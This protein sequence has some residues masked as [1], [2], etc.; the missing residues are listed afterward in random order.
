MRVESKSTEKSNNSWSVLLSICALQKGRMILALG[1]IAIVSC[2]QLLPIYL[3]F[4]AIVELLDPVSTSANT[5]LWVAAGLI[6]VT[7]FKTV[8][9]VGAYYFSHQ[10]AYKA[11]TDVRMTLSTNLASAS[12]KWL[13]KQNTAVLK[14]QILHD[15][16]KLEHFIAHNSVELFN[17]C[18]SP[19]LIFCALYLIDWRLALSAIAVVPLAFLVSGFFMHKTAEHYVQFSD[20]EADLHTTLNDY[21]KYA[22][23]MK[24]NNLDSQRFVTLKRKL[25]TYQSTVNSVIH[26]TVPGWALYSA[27]LGS[28][29]LFLLPTAIWLHSLQLVSIEHL[30]LAMLLAIGMMG[31][32]LKVSRFF[33]EANELLSSISRIA[34]LYYTDPV[35]CDTTPVHANTKY[36]MLQ[37]Y[38]VDFCYE[39]TPVLRNVHFKLLPNA[40]NVIVGGTG[41]GKSTL[42]MLASG[43]LAPSAGRV[44]LHGKDVYALS[45]SVRAQA[46]SVVTQEN[47]LFEGTVRDNISFGRSGV[48]TETLEHAIVAAQLKPWLV[49]QPDGLDTRVEARGINL[50]GGEKIRI[51]IARAILNAPP[52]VILDEASAAMD[53]LTHAKF[54]QGLKGHYP[55][56]TFLVITHNYFGLENSDQIFTLIDGTIAAQGTHEAMLVRCEHY[57]KGWQ[58]QGCEHTQRAHVIPTPLPSCES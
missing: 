22:P 19:I 52:L 14:Q 26:Q 42:A 4:V 1:L 36:P 3:L 57:R 18:L 12:L 49:R 50:S 24:L 41:S 51:A 53:N 30:V 34:P 2:A 17:A 16:E 27:L 38:C 15:I 54:Y 35:H 13:N 37:F 32:V 47:Y 55:N 8:F 29:F 45:D 46:M 9:V 10:A 58:L 31:P 28:V 33:M 40:I 20:V 7:V 23:L 25:N 11:L 39:Q 56:T 44:Q 21:V 43:L 6:A 48:S 5:L